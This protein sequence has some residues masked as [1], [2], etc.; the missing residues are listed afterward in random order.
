MNPPSRRVRRF[1]LSHSSH[2][3]QRRFERDA[4]REKMMRGTA[5]SL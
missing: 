5:T 2:G 1:T 4:R 3:P